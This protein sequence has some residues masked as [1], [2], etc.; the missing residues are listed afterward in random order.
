MSVVTATTQGTLRQGVVAS[1]PKIKIQPK[2]SSKHVP[3]MKEAKSSAE[4][5]KSS[6]K[7][8]ALL[9]KKLEDV[10]VTAE[11]RLQCLRC[12]R[13]FK[14]RPS[15]THHRIDKCRDKLKPGPKRKR[16]S[17]DVDTAENG[18]G[19]K[20]AHIADF[21]ATNDDEEL[22]RSVMRANLVL[23]ELLARQ[24]SGKTKA[25]AKPT[26]ADI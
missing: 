2:A 16:R 17:D 3:G 6:D 24:L 9:I 7:S 8:P 18:H 19:E 12:Q 1:R 5:L 4:E 23:G 22:M 10:E 14:N 20:K 26:D 13:D 21:A 11:G 15:F 25:N